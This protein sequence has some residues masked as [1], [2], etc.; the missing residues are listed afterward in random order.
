MIRT[1]TI[2]NSPIYVYTNKI[3]WITKKKMKIMI[4]SCMIIFSYIYD[5]RVLRPANQSIRAW[6]EKKSIDHWFL[7]S[8][9]MIWYD[10]F[11]LRSRSSENISFFM[12]IVISFKD[13][14]FLYRSSISE[15]LRSDKISINDIPMCLCFLQFCKYL[16]YRWTKWVK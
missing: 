10:S 12:K 11:D 16:Y 6:N 3:C 14:I 7:I 1:D 4:I 5:I 13:N 2:L 9:C 15:N 8:I